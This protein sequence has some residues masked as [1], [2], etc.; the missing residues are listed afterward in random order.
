[1]SASVR[2]ENCRFFEP[3]PTAIGACHVRPPRVIGIDP[4]DG[5]PI[6]AQAS[7]SRDGWCGLFERPLL[8]AADGRN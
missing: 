2:C 3:G 4:A 7:T 8:V 1:M 6:S 5:Q